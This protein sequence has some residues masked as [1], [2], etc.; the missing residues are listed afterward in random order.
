MNRNY[1]PRVSFAGDTEE[2]RPIHEALA[3]KAFALNEK[4]GRVIPVG[5]DP[6]LAARERALGRFAYNPLS[7]R[8]GRIALDMPANKAKGYAALTFIHELMHAQDVE[9]LSRTGEAGSR[10]AEILRQAN[11]PPH[12]PAMSDFISAV[13]N[14]EHTKKIASDYLRQPEELTARAFTQYAVDKLN[15]PDLIRSFEQRARDNP[16]YFWPEGEFKEKITPRIEKVLE[17]KNL[18]PPN[19]APSQGRS[20]ASQ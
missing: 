13:Q 15:D 3:Q 1:L 12:S 17:E 14:S 7:S 4:T 19:T 18:V 2:L 9:D 10:E 16:D 5:N 20:G 6:E 8:P 11:L